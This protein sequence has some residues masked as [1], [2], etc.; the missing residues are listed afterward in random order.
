MGPTVTD[1]TSD[2]LW[3]TGKAFVIAVILTPIIRDISRS[4][5]LVD[6][7]GKRKVHVYPLPR[8][9]GI[10]IAIAY[11]VSLISF[12]G[13]ASSVAGSIPAW[14]V[15]PGAAIVFLTGLLDDIF[16][17]K[18]VVKVLGLFAA[19]CTA[20]FCGIRMGGLAHQP[21]GVGLEFPLTIL[22]LLATSN[23]L[24]LI[25]GL[26]GLCA[27]MGLMS[28]LALFAAA[29][30]H[31]NSPLAYAT[32]PLAGALLGFLC[33][34]IS[35]AT[36]FLGDS[37]ALLI[38]FLLGCYGMI[39][40]QKSSTLLSMMVPLLAL[41][42]PLLDVSLSV[43]RRFLRR[44][45]IFGADRGHIHHRLLDRGLSARQA[46]WVL[47]LFAALAAAMALLASSFVGAPYLGFIIV[48]FCAVALIGIRQLRYSE[49]DI[50]GRLLFRGEFHKTVNVR[51]K[52]ESVAGALERASTQEEW[53]AALI[54]GTASLDLAV[55]RWTGPH[56]MR[57]TRK[58]GA[59]PGWSFSL[60]LS[61]SDTV[62][63]E[64]SSTS[65]AGSFDLIGLGEAVQRTFGAKVSSW[66][67]M[68]AE[69]ASP[70][71]P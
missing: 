13:S 39:W 34:N 58:P 63:L 21:L 7:P 29:M 44:Q 56:G 43:L 59:E 40:T 9:G 26:D 69:K 41:S 49:F 67:P 4:F 16:S 53:W 61:E 35:P 14:R 46:V 19:A 18:P 47:L 22:W 57:E 30:L 1:L 50:A 27:G 70:V 52:I 28:T 23:A 32:L 62:E 55:V 31:G 25:D 24:N 38:G 48:A 51:L 66:R 10:A 68:A 45:P 71:L 17:I 64:G 2:V 54:Q 15:L 3:M 60:P 8:V 11:C 65:T 36:V 6:R 12:S 42:I 37:G 5:N 33:Y 20:Y